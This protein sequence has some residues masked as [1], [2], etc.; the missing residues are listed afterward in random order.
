[1]R[2]PLVRGHNLDPD[3]FGRLADFVSALGVGEAHLMPYH[4]LGLDKYEPLGRRGGL[5]AEPGLLDTE[6]GRAEVR[7]ALSLFESRGLTA[8]V[9]G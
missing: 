3:H 9:G 5:A 7:R 2:V 1:M 6:T 8:H 4:E